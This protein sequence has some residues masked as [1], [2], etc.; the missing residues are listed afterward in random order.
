ML[1]Q[2]PKKYQHVHAEYKNEEVRRS[3]QKMIDALLDF[4]DKHPQATRQDLNIFAIGMIES[5]T[6]QISSRR[7]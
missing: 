1:V 6:K 7:K 4:K 2:T 5:R 3:Y